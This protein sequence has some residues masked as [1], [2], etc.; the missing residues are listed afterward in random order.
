MP[1]AVTIEIDG[2]DEIDGDDLDNDE[3][4]RRVLD[5]LGRAVFALV[6]AFDLRM[7][8]M[9]R[10]G[11]EEQA[12]D[13]QDHVVPG[14]APAHHGEDRLGKA[15]QPSQ[16]EQEKNAEDEREAEPD[17][18]RPCHIGGI[19]PRDQDGDE[20]DIVD[21]EDD[22]ERAQGYERCPGVR[23]VQEIEHGTLRL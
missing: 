18:A 2:E 12:A 10:L 21:A 11:D 5:R 23:I 8:L 17:L 20:D 19:E 6:Y 14:E 7:H 13:D 16:A 3:G 15:D 9:R 4:K 1:I 22:F